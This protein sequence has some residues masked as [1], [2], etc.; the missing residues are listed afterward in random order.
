MR[1]R[2]GLICVLTLLHTCLILLY[3][4]PHTA[5]WVLILLYVCPHTAIYVSASCYICVYVSSN[6]CMCP[7]TTIYLYVSTCPHTTTYVPASCRSAWATTFYTST[8][9]LAHK[10]IPQRCC[11]AFFLCFFFLFR[12][13][14]ITYVCPH[15]SIYTTYVFSY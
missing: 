9:G 14:A 12:G 4:C 2:L 3:M 15:K 1:P 13:G 5:I 8:D 6:R 11:I 7:H 10:D